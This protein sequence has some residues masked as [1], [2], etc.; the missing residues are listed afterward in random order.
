MAPSESEA[1]FRS[2]P[3][4]SQIGA[5]ASEAQSS[6]LPDRAEIEAREIALKAQYPEGQ[7]PLPDF[8]GGYRVIPE[9]IEFWQGRVGRLHDRLRYFR[10]ND[11]W[12]IERLSP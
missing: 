12:E 7:V 2:R 8:W 1:Y 5:W 6:V 4:E 9:K 11:N 3:Y 10:E